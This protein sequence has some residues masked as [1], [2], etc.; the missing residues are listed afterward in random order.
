M[1]STH[2]RHNIWCSRLLLWIAVVLR[3]LPWREVRN[4]NLLNVAIN[5]IYGKL[6]KKQCWPVVFPPGLVCGVA[7]ACMHARGSHIYSL[8]FP[9]HPSWHDK[10]VVSI[11][12]FSLIFSVTV[13]GGS[14]S[15]VVMDTLCNQLCLSCGF[16]FFRHIPHAHLLLMG[17]IK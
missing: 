12:K 17:F 4:Y 8:T 6:N 2:S 14:C 5:V 1:N 16:T 7:G 11:L 3:W 15:Q 10:Y 9:A 13:P